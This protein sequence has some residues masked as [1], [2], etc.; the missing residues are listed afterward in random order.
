METT[1]TGSD[2]LTSDDQTQIRT[3]KLPATIAIIIA[4]KR[5]KIYESGTLLVVRDRHENGVCNS[6]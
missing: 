5:F 1:N 4:K 3:L 2:G 6:D